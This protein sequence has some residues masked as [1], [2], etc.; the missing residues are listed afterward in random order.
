MTGNDGHG[1][2]TSRKKYAVS[3]L[4]FTHRDIDTRK[5]RTQ[6]VPSLLA[7]AGTQGDPFGTNCQMSDEVT[8]LW[9]RIYPTIILND[10]RKSIVLGVVR[11]FPQA[12]R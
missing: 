3:D 2:R 11:I 6:F 4:P 1:T 12:R 9:Q 7:W 5:W 10:T 8:T